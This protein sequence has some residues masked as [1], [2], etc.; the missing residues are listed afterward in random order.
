MANIQVI[1]SAGISQLQRNF[2]DIDDDYY[3]DCL[4][5]MRWLQ[6]ED[7]LFNLNHL[8]EYLAKQR[9][10]LPAESYNKKLKAIKKRLRFTMQQNS[11]RLSMRELEAMNSIISG[12]DKAEAWKYRKTKQKEFDVLTESEYQQLIAAAPPKVALL[13]EFLYA[14]GLRIS[15]AVNLL[16][17]NINKT[18]SKGKEYMAC[19]AIESKNGK[20]TTKKIPIDLYNRIVTEFGKNK[21][22]FAKRKKIDGEYT[23]VPWSRQAAS[24]AVSRAGIAV[25]GTVSA[26]HPDGRKYRKPAREITAHSLRHARATH[27]IN[28]G[29]SIQAVSKFLDHSDVAITS[30]IYDHTTL[31][32]EDL[33][34]ETA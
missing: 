25:F 28:E 12:R 32:T 22:L 14:T 27:L 23:Y 11:D 2:T 13:I 5:V 3:Y 24:L 17:P 20:D 9:E 30:R 26:E 19:T 6:A 34:P 29:H 21:Y 8:T 15:D 31:S 7:K 16:H 33:F 4:H 18:V 1:Q 10:E